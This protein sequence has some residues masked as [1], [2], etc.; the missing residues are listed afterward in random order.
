MNRFYLL[1]SVIMAVLLTSC[2][3]LKKN[4]IAEDAAVPLETE[5]GVA[6]S[7]NAAT[8]PEDAAIA[9]VTKT[10]DDADYAQSDGTDAADYVRSDL[11]SVK[12]KVW[13]LSEVRLGYGST[14][15]N[16]ELLVSNQMG[17]Y[18]SLQFINEGINGTAAPNR[19]FA[20]YSLIDGSNVMIH[21][22][23]STLIASSPAIGVI[24][25]QRFFS[26]LQEMK[27]W[28]E[29]DSIL[30]IYSNNGENQRDTIMI[31]TLENK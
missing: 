31:F 15:L 13:L 5:A 1:L 26:L 17:N 3:F 4:K 12:N 29:N 27:R 10:A 7:E 11:E 16:R 19:Y 25:E 8:Q 28:G 24:D 6:T 30:H 21:P 22:I 14:M 18:Y 23:A 9:A 2:A 20:P